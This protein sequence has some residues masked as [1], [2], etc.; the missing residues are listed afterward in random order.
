VVCRWD[1][2][3]NSGQ[4]AWHCVVDHWSDK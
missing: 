2:F 4:G 3:A 1:A